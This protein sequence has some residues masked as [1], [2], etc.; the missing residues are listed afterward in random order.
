MWAIIDPLMN[1]RKGPGFP[2]L[3]IKICVIFLE[4]GKISVVRIT[5]QIPDLALSERGLKTSQNE[6]ILTLTDGSTDMR[7]SP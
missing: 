5:M 1:L 6:T 4:P 7:I 2:G 3:L